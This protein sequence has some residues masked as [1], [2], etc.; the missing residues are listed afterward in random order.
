MDRYAQA[1][2][3]AAEAHSGQFRKGTLIPYVTHPVGV[4]LMVAQFGGDEDQRVAAVLHDVLEDGGAHY[5]ERILGLGER[6]LEIVE[7]CT[8]SIPDASG[9]KVPWRQRK[10][11]YLSAL[12]NKSRDI[13]LVCGCDKLFNARDIVADLRAHGSVVFERFSA[14]AEGTLWYYGELQRLFAGRD[15]PFVDEFSSLCEEMRKL[16]AVGPCVRAVKLS[17]REGCC[18]SYLAAHGGRATEHAEGIEARIMGSLV[19]KGCCTQE[20]V[21]QETGVRAW[22]ITDAGRQRVKSIY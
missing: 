2:C 18:L 21:C 12:A 14:G 1:V 3:L 13:L 8:D 22:C 17:A 6:V 15:L 11:A 7:G 19:R 4:S 5:R 20:A 16:A 10:E 9:R